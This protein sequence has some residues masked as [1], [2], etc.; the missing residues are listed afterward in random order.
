MENINIFHKF[1][2]NTNYGDGNMRKS[3]IDFELVECIINTKADLN[4]ANKNF[5]Q[6]EGDLI[7][8]YSYQIKANQTKLDYLMK[9]ARKKGIAL[10]MI[11]ELYIKNNK[12]Q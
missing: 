5:E 6:A 7:D 3:K 4:V 9:K 11:N 8:Y 1:T 12:A 10:D 2:Y